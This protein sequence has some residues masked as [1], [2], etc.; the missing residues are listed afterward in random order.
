MKAKS[1]FIFPQGHR[2]KFIFKIITMNRAM[3]FRYCHQILH[4]ISHSPNSIEDFLVK[5]S[6][7]FSAS[8]IYVIFSSSLR[9]IIQA[10]FDSFSLIK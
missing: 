4:L 10:M 1:D 7:H 6:M 9:L 2:N 3:Y 5:T 8:F